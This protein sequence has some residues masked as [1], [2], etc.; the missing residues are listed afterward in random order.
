MILIL[1][2]QFFCQPN[3]LGNFFPKLIVLQIKRKL[4]YCMLMTTSLFVF[5]FLSS[6]VFTSFNGTFLD[7][8]GPEMKRSQSQNKRCLEIFHHMLMPISTFILLVVN[9]DDFDIYSQNC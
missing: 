1:V 7:K 8:L 6:Y 5:H 2:F 9:A 3:I 4:H